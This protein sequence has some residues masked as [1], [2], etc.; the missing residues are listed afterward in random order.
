M[1]PT[2][3]MLHLTYRYIVMKVLKF[4]SLFW[5][6]AVPVIA[7]GC[8]VIAI[9]SFVVP[10]QLKQNTINS[11]IHDAEKTVQQFKTIRA[12]YTNNVVKTILQSQDIRPSIDH[13]GNSKAIPLPATMIHDL[14]QMLKDKG[15]I[16]D[17]YSKFPF[18]NRSDR[19]LDSFQQR[20]WD[21]LLEKPD[22]TFSE[23]QVVDGKPVLRVAVA[24]KMVSQACVN[25]HNSRGDTPKNDWKLGD[26]R[27]VLEIT[28]DIEKQINAGT[29]ANLTIL[30]IIAVALIVMLFTIGLLFKITVGSRL[31]QLTARLKDIAIGDGDLTQRMLVTGDDEISRLSIYFNQFIDKIHNT[32]REVSTVASQV[33]DSVQG[34]DST[35]TKVSKGALQQQQET[36]SI[37]SAVTEMSAISAQVNDSASSAAKETITADNSAKNGKQI[38]NQTVDSIHQLSSD[39][40]TA[41]DVIKDLANQAENIGSVLDEIRGIANQ[42]NL[43]ALNAAIEAARA[44][45]QGRGFAVVAD[46]VR[47]LASRT[48]VSTE[49]IQVMIESLQSGT[50]QAVSVMD[51]G[52]SQVSKTVEMAATAGQS[53]DVI[54]SSVAEISAMNNQIAHAA[55]EQQKTANSVSQNVLAIQ[56][57]ADETAESS[58]TAR[59]SSDS[60]SRHAKMLKTMMQQFEI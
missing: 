3:G 57:V 46:E 31:S 38:V 30:I 28:A 32:I 45:E 5:Q 53:L 41:A 34:L 8:L 33:V 48:Q 17:L 56:I 1:H 4:S 16:L 12:Y 29:D 51:K 47:T 9:L 59:Q 11:A 42:T 21:F 25:C 22:G 52:Q 15:T 6:L 18:P 40:S 10:G 7:I 2:F 49:E 19:Q 36:G 24:D 43:L 13:K 44:G 50:K 58:S 27:G 14:S 39:V 55:G 54:V 35:I 23:E 37:A 20:A 60:V 26:V